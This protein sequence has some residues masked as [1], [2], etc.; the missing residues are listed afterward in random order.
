MASTVCSPRADVKNS[1]R[2]HRNDKLNRAIQNFLYG[3]LQ[4]PISDPL[5]SSKAF[6]QN[7]SVLPQNSIFLVIHCKFRYENNS[8]FTLS[9]HP[10]FA[11]AQQL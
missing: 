8:P 2:K 11:A 5:Q 4:V 7:K 1:N 9:E 10:P 6:I 3:A